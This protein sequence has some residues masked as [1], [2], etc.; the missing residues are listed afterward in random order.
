MV[1][2]I[3]IDVDVAWKEAE[4][5][6]VPANALRPPPCERASGS[7]ESAARIISPDVVVDDDVD[8]CWC[9]CWWCCW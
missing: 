5:E 9:C 3:A 1:L 6:E 8:D 2:F 7:G 4:D